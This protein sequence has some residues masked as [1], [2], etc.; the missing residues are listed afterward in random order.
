MFNYNKPMVI[1]QSERRKMSSFLFRTIKLCCLV[2]EDAG[3]K[4]ISSQM[5]DCLLVKE[6]KIRNVNDEP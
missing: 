3:P 2:L 5:F 1:N 4:R 6:K